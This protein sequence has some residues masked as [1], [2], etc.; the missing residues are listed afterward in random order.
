M[1][2]HPTP[3]E[4]LFLKTLPPNP[5]SNTVKIANTTREKKNLVGNREERFIVRGVVTHARNP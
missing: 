3:Q 5:C 1:N 2:V 4:E